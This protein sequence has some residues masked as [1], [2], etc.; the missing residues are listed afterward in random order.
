MPKLCVLLFGPLLLVACSQ[1]NGTTVITQ[2]SSSSTEIS[3]NTP[4]PY[5]LPNAAA[6]MTKKFFGTYV[7]PQ[8]SPVQP[9]RFTGFHTGV[10]FE[11]F[12]D[13]QNIDV[14]VQAVCG[15]SVLSASWVSG[16]GGVLVQ[17]CTWNGEAVTILY[18][19]LNVDS[20]TVKKGA[21]VTTG[22]V[23]GN[24]G[25]GFSTQTDGERKHLH[26]SV[27]LGTAV[28]FRGYVTSQDQLSGWINPYPQKP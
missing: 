28:N 11:T 23:I 19:H 10:D 6:R 18:G 16:Y 2:S 21:A 15:G 24:L 4:L 5:P 3:S 27:H 22:M 7:T 20:L 12:P 9:E 1:G 17:S 25:K 8:N 26:L 14:P 13:E